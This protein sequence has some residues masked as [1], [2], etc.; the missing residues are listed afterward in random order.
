MFSQ[1]FIERPK[2]AIVISLVMVLAGA[3]CINKLP[4]AEYPEIAPPKINVEAVYTGASAEV[5][6]ETVGIPLE[7]E[8]NG[9][10]DLLYFSSTSNN[11]GSYSCS[12]TF[13]SGTNSDIA[14]VNVQNA[15]KRAEPKLPSE[16]TKVGVNVAKRSSDILAMI[17][18]L[19]DGTKLN[20]IQ[21]CNF[22]TVNIKDPLARLD[23]VAAVS[24]LA[25]KE[26]SMRVWMD[27]LRMSAIGI[28]T[29]E[30]TSAI[31]SQNLQAAA[32]SIGNENSNDFVEYKVN[33]LGRLKT[34]EQF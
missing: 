33:V 34:A 13:K 11:N 23:G 18:F 30:I 10:E 22:V 27:P 6:A 17:S 12:I 4:V 8:L 26:Y 14:M 9:L 31:N 1:I 24:I 20:A 7:N 19:S 21:L 3:I 28:T 32:G 2:L 29:N 16:V 5:I 25:A 15:I